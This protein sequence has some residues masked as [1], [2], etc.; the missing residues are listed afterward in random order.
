[1]ERALQI[2][3]ASDMLCASLEIKLSPAEQERYER[4]KELSRSGQSEKL[5]AS[6][7]KKGNAMTLERAVAFALA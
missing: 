3:G 7:Y 6:A 5:V 1:M 2:I 4:N